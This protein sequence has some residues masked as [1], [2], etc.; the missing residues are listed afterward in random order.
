[1]TRKIVIRLRAKADMREARRW[2]E[3]QRA[4]LGAQFTAA[5]EATLGD[6][7]AIPQRFPEVCPGYRRAL[8]DRFPYKVIFREVGQRIVVVA[9]Y[10]NSRDPAGWQ[11][12]IDEESNR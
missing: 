3:R 5:V 7:L 8:L 9:V 11:E 4:D 6:I 12:R 2:Y 1:V 10:H